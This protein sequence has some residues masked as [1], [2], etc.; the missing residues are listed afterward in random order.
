MAYPSSPDASGDTVRRLSVGSRAV[1]YAAFAALVVT[2]WLGYQFLW[3]LLFIWWIAPSLRT[4]RAFLVA[5]VNRHEDAFLFWLI[6]ILF[7][8]LGGLMVG[9]DAFP[10]LNNYV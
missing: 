7:A 1:N 10:A 2:T 4:G 3:G 8:A 6:V 9:A 5:E